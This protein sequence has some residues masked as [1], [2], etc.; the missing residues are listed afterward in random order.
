MIEEVEDKISAKKF[1]YDLA[2]EK[3]IKNISKKSK[4][5]IIKELEETE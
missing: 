3:G 5:E 4:E 2:K 1:I